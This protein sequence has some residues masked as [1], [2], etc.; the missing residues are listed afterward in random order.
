MA[1]IK[2]NRIKAKNSKGNIEKWGKQGDKISKGWRNNKRQA[3]V[4]PT[5]LDLVNKCQLA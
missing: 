5:L 3:L 2:E 4:R 1:Q